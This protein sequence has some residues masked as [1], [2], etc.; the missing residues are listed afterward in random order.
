MYKIKG[1][2]LIE[3]M[4]ALLIF[5]TVAILCAQG[6]RSISMMQQRQREIINETSRVQ[7][8]YNVLQ[9]DLMQSVN[10][11]VRIQNDN[12]PG[13][14]A[15]KFSRLNDELFELTSM[16]HR[17]PNVEQFNYS[18]LRRIGYFINKHSLIRAVWKNVNQ[19]GDEK[20]SRKILASDI[21]SIDIH[22]FNSQAQLSS[23]WQ[24]AMPSNRSLSQGQANLEQ[25]LPVAMKINLTLLNGMHYE[26]FFK[27][28]G[29]G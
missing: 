19:V 14:I 22:Y 26:W 12:I 17:N 5:A 21:N 1:F 11:P 28:P 18:S 27:L 10:R 4:I 25:S 20:P 23:S 6:I 9:T 3:T 24:S 2:T 7:M 8:I 13:F 16:G 15:G 29:G